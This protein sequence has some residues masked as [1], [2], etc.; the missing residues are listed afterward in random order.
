MPWPRPGPRA[1]SE[2]QGLILHRERLSPLDLTRRLSEEE[3]PSPREICH[4]A[5][6]VDRPALLADRVRFSRKRDRPN[7]RA[8]RDLSSG[9]IREAKNGVIASTAGS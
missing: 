3:I 9:K 8:S 1:Q 5:L 4:L 2:A 7:P 6:G